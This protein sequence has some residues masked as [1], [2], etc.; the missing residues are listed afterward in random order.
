MIKTYYLVVGICRYR[1]QLGRLDRI[2]KLGDPQE[3]AYVKTR[4]FTIQWN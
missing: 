1:Q 4:D 2:E 3:L